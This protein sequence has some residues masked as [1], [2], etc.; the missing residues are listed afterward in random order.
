VRSVRA[1]QRGIN[2]GQVNTLHYKIVIEF[3]NQSD[4]SILETHS[5]NRIRKH[6]LLIQKFLGLYRESPKATTASNSNNTTTTSDY[7]P[8]TQSASSK[9]NPSQ[10]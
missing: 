9:T 1:A 3:Y 8:T 4:L 10:K 2:K 5:A 6:L 7:I